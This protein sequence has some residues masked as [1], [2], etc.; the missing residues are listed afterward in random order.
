MEN[1][2]NKEIE[3]ARHEAVNYFDIAFHK[4]GTAML[5]VDENLKM[6][7]RDQ[8]FRIVGINVAVHD[9]HQLAEEPVGFQRI[10]KPPEYR[11]DPFFDLNTIQRVSV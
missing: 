10:D 6:I 2:C 4:T 5:I 3:N 9:V 11:I 7:R 8:L 1:N